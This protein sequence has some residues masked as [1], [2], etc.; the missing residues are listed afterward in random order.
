MTSGIRGIAAYFPDRVRKNDEWPEEFA[1]RLAQAGDRLFNDIPEAEDA[2]GRVT[3]RFLREEAQDPFLGA[4]ERRVADEAMT[5]WQ[6]ELI[7]ARAAL[8][9]AQLTAS[10]IDVVIS[11]SVT[12]DRFTPA[13]AARVA[14]ELGMNDTLCFGMDAACASALIQLEMAVGFVS[15]GRAKNVLLT[16]SHLLLRAFPM[17]HPAAPGL[18][19]AATALVVSAQGRWPILGT[20]SETHAEYHDAVTWVR[21]STPEEDTGFWHTGQPF[22]VGSLDRAQAKDL[23]R[24]TVSYGARTVSELCARCG[25]DVERLRALYSVEPR[26]WVPGAVAEV[27]G[28]S[29]GVAGSIYPTRGHLGA[30]GPIANLEHAYRSGTL[31]NEGPIALYAQGAGFSRASVLLAMD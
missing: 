25:I 11:Y 5:S 23:Q 4:R 26:G 31:P 16:Q 3:S 1:Q 18:G 7:A 9:D 24:D 22:R 27:L 19:D 29:P 15:S 28:L 6:A 13:S 21:G 8:S 12:P 17:L 14:H 2:A 30:C 10:E 20:R